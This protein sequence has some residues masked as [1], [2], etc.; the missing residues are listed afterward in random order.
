[1]ETLPWFSCLVT[2]SRGSASILFEVEKRRKKNKKL[3]QEKRFYSV[4]RKGEGAL[5]KT[6]PVSKCTYVSFWNGISGGVTSRPFVFRLFERGKFWNSPSSKSLWLQRVWS[7]KFPLLLLPPVQ[8]QKSRAFQVY[9]SALLR[10]KLLR[11]RHISKLLYYCANHT[12]QPCNLE[13]NGRDW[14]RIW[15]RAKV[16]PLPLKGDISLA[17]LP[18]LYTN[19]R[20]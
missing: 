1:M 19:S 20:N 6:S 14:H 17:L 12:C 15:Q 4:K 7:P 5:G 13:T 2:F 10:A 3:R 11:F 18:F 16:A 8:S 9:C